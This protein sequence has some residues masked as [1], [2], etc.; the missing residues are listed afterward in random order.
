M[1]LVLMG[2]PGAGKG[3][4]AQMLAER[5]QV[6]H[7]SSGDIFRGEVRR[8]T[9]LGRRIEKYLGAGALVPDDITVE[10]V[11][12]RLSESDAAAG[13]VLDG[14]PRTEGQARA[15][16]RAL[17]AQ[18]RRLT[19][20]VDLAVSEATIVQRMAGRRSCP[21]CGRVYHVANMPPRVAG[22]CDACGAD[23]VVR[24][25][26]RPETVR[27]RLKTYQA[28]TAP[29]IEYYAESGLLVRVDGE[30]TP[31]GIRARLLDRLDKVRAD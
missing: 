14:F 17:D 22:K 2:P 11:M 29:L 10:A 21:A 28:Q 5:Y 16:D 4:A 7:V 19:A 13:W 3:T 20:V 26:D 27:A 24:K 6:P 30:G 15:L 1:R 18:G 8:G 25:D 23:L 12:G 31:E 9:D